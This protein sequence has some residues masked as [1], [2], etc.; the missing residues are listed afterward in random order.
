MRKRSDI[1][2]RWNKYHNFNG[3]YWRLQTIF[4]EFKSKIIELYTGNPQRYSLSLFLSFCVFIG[5]QNTFHWT[6][7]HLPECKEFKSIEIV[8]TVRSNNKHSSSMCVCV[9]VEPQISD[10]LC[11]AHSYFDMWPCLI[12]LCCS[13]S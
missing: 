11:V 6:F 10:Y 2:N 7:N 12:I 13:S 4:F 1:M 5:G 3:F 9:C 8:V